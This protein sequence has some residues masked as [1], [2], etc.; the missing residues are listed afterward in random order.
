M[1]VERHSALSTVSMSSFLRIQS[2]GA[3]AQQHL[4]IVVHIAS[5]E[6]DPN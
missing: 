2:V 3:T 1:L 4:R 5:L 6:K